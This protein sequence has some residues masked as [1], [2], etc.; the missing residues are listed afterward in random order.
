M[1]LRPRIEGGVWTRGRHA[2]ERLLWSL[3]LKRGQEVQGS[4]IHGRLLRT[5]G[6]VYTPATLIRPV[7]AF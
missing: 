2:I 6:N 5:G 3:D 1:P 7:V 4:G